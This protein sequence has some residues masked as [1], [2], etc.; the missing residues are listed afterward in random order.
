MTWR[1]ASELAAMGLP[2]LPGSEFRM[3]QYL[4]RI[5]VPS[6]QRSGRCGGG[7]REFDTTALPEEARRV[8][9]AASVQAVTLP[10]LIEDVP[11]TESFLPA[12]KPV[13]ALV[14]AGRKPPTKADAACADARTQLVQHLVGAAMLI[15]ITRAAAALSEQLKTGEADPALLAAAA[16]ANRRKRAVAGGVQISERTLFNW[17]KA[18]VEGGWWG[19]LPEA[20]QARPLSEVPPDVAMVLK[21]YASAKG[22]ARNLTEVAQKITRE[23]GRD[24]DTW[25]RLYDQARRALPKLDRTQ[26]IKARHTGG[27]RAARLP[28]RRRGTEHLAALDVGVIDGH[29]FKAK[30]RHPDHGQPFKPEVSLVLDAASRRITGW[31]ASLSESV[32]AVG[33]A[34]CH[35]AMTSGIHAVMY[36]DNGNGETAKELDCPL[37]GLYSRIGMHHP[38]GRPGN[39]QGRGIIER[40]W[41]THMIRA[42]RQFDTFQGADVDGPTLRKVELELQREQRAVNRAR[43]TGD[44]VTLSNK[45]PTWQQFLDA[46]QQAIDDYNSKHRHRGLPKHTSGPKQGL[47]MTPNEAWA[48]ML[49]PE[50][51]TRPTAEEA[52]LLFQPSKIA[53]ARR[54][55]VQ[56]LTLR[57]FSEALM[58]V[59]GE[60][61]SVRYDI[62][63]PRQV[64]IW[65][66]DGRFVCEAQLDANRSDFFPKSVVEMA[67]EKRVKGMVQRAQQRID[68]AER[69]LTPGLEGGQPAYLPAAAMVPTVD[70]PFPQRKAEL[71]ERVAEPAPAPAVAAPARRLFDSPSERYEWLMAHRADWAEADHAWLA[72]YVA[73][74]DYAQ[75]STYYADRGLAWE[76]S[77]SGFKTAG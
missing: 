23:L 71:V 25:R 67:R 33:A 58:Q 49:K 20:S 4:D 3:R 75:L 17:H 77:A 60:R 14:P 69:E 21:A 65:T 12:P 6:R 9:L 73:S 32:M 15:G 24:F 2:G 66:L 74:A 48:A 1:T 7:G 41:R 62:H 36:S 11:P 55:E 19:L 31:S 68:T 56:F 43:T 29:G 61:V 50:L 22:S 16:C 46:V 44:V 63:D 26:L 47:H 64:W 10:G 70:M 28:F 40:S 5:G 45:V 34:L 30:V 42:A 35:S 13:A 53:V 18:Y 37:D 72:R 27:D 52:R 57:Y 8:V 76:A 59:D 38:T 54:G 39:P 51:V